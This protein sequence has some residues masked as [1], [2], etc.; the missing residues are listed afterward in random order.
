ME[1]LNENQKKSLE[2][3]AGVQEIIETQGS[4]NGIEF[5]FKNSLKANFCKLVEY[6]DK[7]IIQLRKITENGDKLVFESV[8][9][10]GEFSE[11]FQKQTGISI[12]YYQSLYK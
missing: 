4:R 2:L 8:I 11:V 3:L 6:Q 7:Y 5:N 1:I 12:D 10:E 9:K